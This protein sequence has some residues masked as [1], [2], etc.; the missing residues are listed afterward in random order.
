MINPL[1]H[2]DIV[3][4]DDSGIFVQRGSVLRY[5]DMPWCSHLP[6]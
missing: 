5:E 4:R 2:S 3:A 6:F 1:S